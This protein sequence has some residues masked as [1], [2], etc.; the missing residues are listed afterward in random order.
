MSGL[1][2]CEL[3][4]FWD[5]S[6]LRNVSYREREGWCKRHAPT[7]LPVGEPPLEVRPH[8]PAMLGHEWC[9]DFERREELKR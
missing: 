3:C 5:N 8:F 1:Q 2:R 6:Q 9:G 4:R 7:P